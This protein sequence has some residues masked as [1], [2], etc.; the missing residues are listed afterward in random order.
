MVARTL[1]AP[2]TIHGRGPAGLTAARLLSRSGFT[3]RLAG[4]A[5]AGGPTTL[6]NPGTCRLL[7]ELWGIALDA[8]PSRYRLRYRAVHPPAPESPAVVEQH[9]LVVE[10]AALGG[11]LEQR[12]FTEYPNIEA[13]EEDADADGWHL[14]ATG[15]ALRDGALG[16][17][18]AVERVGRARCAAVEVQPSAGFSADRATFEAV[19]GGWLF[20]MPTGPKSAILQAQQDKPEPDTDLV[21]ANLAQS[22]AVRPLVGNLTTTPRTFEAMPRLSRPRAGSGWLAVGDAAMA[23]P[24]VTGDGVGNGLRTAIL[25]TAVL[26]ALRRGEP[27]SAVLAHYERRLEQ[28]FDKMAQR[29]G[30]RSSGTDSQPNEVPYR[31]HGL[32]LV[33]TGA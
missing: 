33:R 19:P 12:L 2:V 29:T 3:C 4:P 14:L 21:I 32:D 22:K 27:E 30:H 7:G 16:T 23:L 8:L 9:S 11:F 1:A 31:L 18:I 26:R 6:L 10:G 25:A 17:D 5:S 13:V 20:L 28:A 15:R 24:P